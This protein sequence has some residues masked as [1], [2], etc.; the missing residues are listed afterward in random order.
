MAWHG[1]LPFLYKQL[2]L[3]DF[4]IRYRNMSLGMLW[5]LLNP[6]VMLGVLAFVFT[7]IFP[8]SRPQF[9]VFILCGIIPFNFFSLAWQTG[10][11]SIISNVGLIKRVAVPREVIPLS[12]VLSSV[13]HL[14]IQLAML[15][16]AVLLYGLRPGLQ[17]FWMIVIWSLEIIFV[18]GL[19]LLFTALNVFIQDTRYFV[20]SACTVLFWLVPIFYDFKNVPQKY[21]ELYQLNP[22]AAIVLAMRNILIDGKAPSNI[23]MIKLA[24]V[25]GVT[26]AIGAIVF[27]RLQRNF[28]EQL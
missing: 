10:T 1:D 28:Y 2:I 7:Q 24:L 18:C 15:L 26:L 22:V 16:A 23:L 14:A 12:T 21:A 6:L 9:P 5:S 27:Q 3:K 20:E 25:S 11:V 17:W 13:P 19:S 8:S 4:R